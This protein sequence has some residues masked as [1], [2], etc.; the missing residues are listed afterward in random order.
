MRR[1]HHA[2][3]ALVVLAPLVCGSEDPSCPDLW[4]ELVSPAVLD[5]Q[6]VN[7]SL[8]TPVF[9]SATQRTI[10]EDPESPGCGRSLECAGSG[11][12]EIELESV[13]SAVVHID[14]DSVHTLG[15]SR[16]SMLSRC[17]LRSRTLGGRVNPDTGHLHLRLE[18]RGFETSRG[19]TCIQGIGEDGLR[20]PPLVLFLADR[21]RNEDD[22]SSGE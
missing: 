17:N 15:S 18:G 20:T 1:L 19:W 11:F 6:Q 14:S 5:R 8:P 3:W 9:I 10:K 22:S 16:D 7:P 12:L 13:S 4:R 21:I 2:P